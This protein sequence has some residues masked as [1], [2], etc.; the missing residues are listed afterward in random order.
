[1]KEKPSSI[2][3]AYVYTC[4]CVYIYISRDNTNIKEGRNVEQQRQAS[5]L[6]VKKPVRTHTSYSFNTDL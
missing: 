5:S 6:A 3:Y 1:M 2:M 4:I